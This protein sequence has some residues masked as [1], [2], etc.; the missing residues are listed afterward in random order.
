MGQQN[1]GPTS[2]DRFV[3]FLFVLVFFFLNKIATIV[4]PDLCF[5]SCDLDDEAQTCQKLYI[6]KKEVN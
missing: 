3:C 4:P 5:Y 6:R 1:N 2:A